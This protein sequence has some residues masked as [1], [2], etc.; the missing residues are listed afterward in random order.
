MAGVTYGKNR[1]A[2]PAVVDLITPTGARVTVS[3]ERAANLLTR[4][5]ITMPDGELFGYELDE[6]D[7]PSSAE[8]SDE[9]DKSNRS[10]RV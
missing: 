3:A 6:T 9:A 1:K 7:E 10:E 5:P 8:K 4:S 2:A